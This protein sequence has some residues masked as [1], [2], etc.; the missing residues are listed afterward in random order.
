M[1]ETIY[2]DDAIRAI[3]RMRFEELNSNGEE[4]VCKS[5]VLSRLAKVPAV[6]QVDDKHCEN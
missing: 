6:V 4:L 5:D 2:K 1:R 3:E